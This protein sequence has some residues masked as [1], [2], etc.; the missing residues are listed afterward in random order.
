MN[1]KFIPKLLTY[2]QASEILQ[3]SERTMFTLVKTNQLNAV[4]FGHSVR[5]DRRDLEK[6]IQDAKGREGVACVD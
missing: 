3:V 2:K 5:I 4:R 6:F 1:D